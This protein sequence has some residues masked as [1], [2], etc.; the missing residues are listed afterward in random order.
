MEKT[1]FSRKRFGFYFLFLLVSA[2]L[3]LN[4]SQ[5]IILAKGGEI[6]EESEVRTLEIEQGQ[7]LY[8]SRQEGR[9][10]KG[11]EQVELIRKGEPYDLPAD[12]FNYWQDGE[13]AQLVYPLL[14]TRSLE[15]G[16]TDH[17]VYHLEEEEV[18]ISASQLRE[19]LAADWERITVGE[20]LMIMDYEIKAQDFTDSLLAKLSPGGRKL[21]LSLQHYMIATMRTAVAVMDRESGEIDFVPQIIE[22]SVSTVFWSPEAEYLVFTVTDARGYSSLYIVGVEGPDVILSFPD[23]DISEE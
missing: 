5:G 22:R 4:C 1:P 21:F 9:I 18:M 3:V 23:F 2:V 17:L 15:E 8:L 14:I 12:T 19:E 7:I 16:R 11:G 10:Q 20:P 13:Y 6:A